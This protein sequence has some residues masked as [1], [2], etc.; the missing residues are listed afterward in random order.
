MKKFT[1]IELLVVIVIIAILISMLMPSLS[2][3]REKARIV[4]CASNES[5]ISK[6]AFLYAAKYDRKIPLEYTSSKRYSMRYYRTDIP[7]HTNIGRFFKSNILS[8]KELLLCP[9]WKPADW[10][11]SFIGLGLELDATNRN[12]ARTYYT[13]RPVQ[14]TNG[15]NLTTSISDYADVA[16]YAEQMYLTYGKGKKPAHKKGMNISYG[17]GH[18]QWVKLDD[19]VIALMS[20]N[21]T[22]NANVQ[23]SWDHFDD[24]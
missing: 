24:Q 9:S 3:A 10:E 23:A 7:T 5:Q 17:D 21:F 13:T 12:D 22:S 19:T 15:S 11:Y 2:R 6:M 1:L 16:I 20:V 8:S 14:V 4:A 18:T